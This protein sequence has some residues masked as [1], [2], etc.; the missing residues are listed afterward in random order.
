M[1]YYDSGDENIDPIEP[2]SLSVS[3]KRARALLRRFLK[4]DPEAV[5]AELLA[6][7][8]DTREPTDWPATRLGR[9]FEELLEA[10]KELR[11]RVKAK[12]ALK[13]Q[14]RA[15]REAAKAEK[16]RQA[17]MEEMKT[18]PNAWLAEAEQTAAARGNV[19]Y[20]AAADIL[21]DLR[22]AIG[23]DKGKELACDGAKE[24]AKAHPTLKM[25]KSALRKRGLL[26]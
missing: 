26:D 12:E 11:T 10:T 16:Q 9:S 20:K 3:E 6:E 5:R 13:A 18:S 2:W 7:I 4:D 23:G 21:A 15:R 17:R 22:E 8:R 19:N 14:A 24:L 25:L 1:P